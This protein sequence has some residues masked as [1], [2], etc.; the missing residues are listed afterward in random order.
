M[1][2]NAYAATNSA[3]NTKKA[4]VVKAATTK[5][6]TQPKKPA[7]S[8]QAP[9][10]PAPAKTPVKPTPTKAPVKPLVKSAPANVSS[11]DGGASTPMKG[12]AVGAAVV[13]AA[14]V[15]ATAT[16]SNTTS[17]APIA[18]TANSNAT[19]TSSSSTDSS[20]SPSVVVVSEA[21]NSSD[22][23]N[24]SV[25]DDDIPG[26]ASTTTTSS[27]ASL[28][29]SLSDSN[30]STG[31]ATASSSNGTPETA[32]MK[33]DE[34]VKIEIAGDTASDDNATDNSSV[35][36]VDKKPKTEGDDDKANNS[37]SPLALQEELDAVD[38]TITS[39]GTV[40]DT[41]DAGSDN[42]SSDNASGAGAGAVISKS[43]EERLKTHGITV[44]QIP[45]LAQQVP[46]IDV[47]DSSIA[48]FELSEEESSILS[49]PSVIDSGVSESVKKAEAMLA[50]PQGDNEIRLVC[51]M[52]P[53]S[54]LATFI[55]KQSLIY[56]GYNA[57]FIER[58]FS[59][60]YRDVGL[61]KA[62]IAMNGWAVLKPL[63]LDE[64]ERVEILP[65]WYTRAV[66]GLAVPDYVD[67][68]IKSI[69]DLAKTDIFKNRIFALPMN[70][71]VT[72]G[73]IDAMKQYNLQYRVI[74][75]EGN[76]IYEVTDNFTS[77]KEPIVITMGNPNGVVLKH[78]LRFL[79]DPKNVF[80]GVD[81]IY[82]V[83]SS[84]LNLRHP[85]VYNFFYNFQ[86]GVDET[87]AMLLEYSD[88]KS[89]DDIAKAWVATHHDLIVSWKNKKPEKK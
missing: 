29:S 40:V 77:R 6:V 4:P 13:G 17:D 66:V 80:G 46:Q 43:H 42:A 64:G 58:D 72:A 53:D 85:E 54:A 49:M 27:N 70:D 3:S 12:A 67:S 24:A 50:A 52:W 32:D 65:P 1:F 86:L 15:A 41:A 47:N 22:A 73:A 8:K 30:S 38:N 39:N 19:T 9:A 71:R 59:I 28:N 20:S 56:L 33:E 69:A 21:S 26:I 81:G 55:A 61:G 75:N 63:M 74:P 76:G 83:V 37:D 82:K 5:P 25:S 2:T 34:P 23:T 36:D 11:A 31:D 48:K 62:D 10:K 88:G 89:L 87:N 78:H 68:N 7:P 84:M 60:V 51:P 79:D 35:I 14:A 18:A 45:E 16:G 44:S 57:V